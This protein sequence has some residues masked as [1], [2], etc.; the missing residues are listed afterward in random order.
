MNAWT[1]LLLGILF[2]VSA[3]STLKLSEGFTK[4]L[5]TTICLLGFCAA[6]YAL[7][8]AVETLEI[9]VVYAIW[10]GAGIVLIALIGIVFY[11]ETVNLTKVFFTT[12]VLIGVVGLQ[13]QSVHA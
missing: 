1:Y 5:P 12:L 2:E 4:P 8:K 9:G 11:G 3:T 13:L 7:S 10:S 6:L